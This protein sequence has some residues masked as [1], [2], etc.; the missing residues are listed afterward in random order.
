MHAGGMLV[1]RAAEIDR[2]ARALDD[3]RAGHGRLVVVAGPAGIGKSRLAD[4]AVEAAREREMVVARGTAV[5]DP[6]AP[7]LWPWTGVLRDLPGA[8]GLALASAD[9]SDAARRFQVFA[10]VEETLA[11]QASA[12][13]LLVVLEDL[14]WADGP[15]LW[16]LRH[17]TASLPRHRIAVVA[18]ARDSGSTAF[19]EVV[20]HLVR[21]DAATVVQVP[22]LAP[23][24]VRAWL[25]HRSDGID[26]ELATALHERTGGVPLL[27]RLVVEELALHPT[28]RSALDRLMVERPQLR[29]LVAARVAALPAA[30]REAVHAAAILG[31]HGDA[32]RIARVLGRPV[33]ETVD[34]LDAAVVAGVLGGGAGLGFAHALIRDAVVA[35]LSLADRDRLHRAA[36]ETLEADG[37]LAVA[38]SIARHWQQVSGRDAAA[39]CAAW[40]EIADDRARAGFAADDALGYAELALDRARVL[41]ADDA[42]QARLLVRVAEAAYLA[43]RLDASLAACEEAADRAQAAARPDL[44]AAAALVVQGVSDPLAVGSVPRLC[45]RALA[46]LPVTEHATRARLIAQLA[47]GLAETEQGA[48]AAEVAAEALVEAERSG[49]DTAILEALAARHVAVSVPDSVT[50]RLDLGRRA[51]ALGADAQRPI[52]ALWGHLWRADA[53]M[54]L[55]NLREYDH[56]VAA[57]AQIARTQRSVLAQWHLHRHR[58]V[59]AVHDGRFATARDETAAA[60]A[61]ARRI[62]EPSMI[63]MAY[64]FDLQLAV[65]LDDPSV[66]APDHLDVLAA[67]PPVPIIAVCIPLTLAVRGDLDAARRHLAGL[68]HIPSTQPYGTRW[69]GTVFQLGVAAVLAGDAALAGEVYDRCAR[70]AHYSSGDGSGAVFTWGANARVVGL[71]AAAAG[72]TAEAERHLRDAVAMNDRVGARP[73]AA[74]SR[75]ALAELLTAG[76]SALPEAAS[77]AAD[78]AAEFRRLDM[79]VRLRRADDLARTVAAAR[80]AASPLSDREREVAD[81]VAQALSNREIAARLVL[82]ERTVETHV[83]NILAKLG[84]SARAEIVAWA[85]RDAAR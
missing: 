5:D 30:V 71:F 24:A 46:A 64:A 35:G 31:E 4:A 29:R 33:H 22:P 12:S 23:E 25:T 56:E 41:G 52:A 54:Q 3:A 18:T 17:V 80:R 83:R 76:G 70:F 11:T 84:F 63:G 57:I 27:V 8:P 6:G 59:R 26:P 77:L 45:E 10:S 82:S 47:V 36:A 40:A 2:I 60:L 34:D 32:E 14:H 66:L 21:G 75:L 38:G 9:E 37:D 61:L 43:G 15:T 28:D 62:G 72:R 49:D 19:D 44:Q 65:V 69:F 48:P 7:P 74:L 85:L 67:A 79:P 51:V 55:G 1:G 50:E 39:R 53:A 81:L 42:E 78:A 16:L 68:R 58:A 20:P 73:F 13:G